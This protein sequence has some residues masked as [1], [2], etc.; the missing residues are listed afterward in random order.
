MI[1]WLVLSTNEYHAHDE[2]IADEKSLEIYSCPFKKFLGGKMRRIQVIFEHMLRFSHSS[3]SHF[4]QNIYLDRIPLQSM[5]DVEAQNIDEEATNS[6]E[7]AT[8]LDEWAEIDR[9]M[10]EGFKDDWHKLMEDASK[11]MYGTCNFSHLTTIC[12]LLNLQ[13][14][15]GWTNESVDELLSFLHE[16]LPPSSTFPTK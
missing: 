8:I 11:P 13:I 14:V 3:I 9:M 2:R 4:P 16:L 12:V 15:H 5:R 10:N 1:Q 7:E 6:D